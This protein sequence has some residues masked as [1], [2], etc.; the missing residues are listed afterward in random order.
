MRKIIY[1]IY[2][3]LTY[4]TCF[5][6]SIGL[7]GKLVTSH[8]DIYQIGDCTFFSLLAISVLIGWSTVRILHHLFYILR[9]KKKD[10]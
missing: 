10:W 7:F 4:S 9:Q 6:T 5:L 3:I 2:D 1:K 8:I